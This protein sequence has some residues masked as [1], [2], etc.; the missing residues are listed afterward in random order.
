[1]GTTDINGEL[2]YTI[3]K[4]LKA[5]NY[6]ITAT[7]TGY[8]KATKSIDIEKYVDYR[9]GIEMPS[10]ANQY[11]TITIKVLY[12]G[13]AMSG[14]SVLFDNTSIGTTDSNG[15]VSYRLETS[16]THSITA[17][18][19]SYIAVSRDVDIRA[20]YSEFKALDINVTPNPVFAGEDFMIKSNIT[21]V[22]TKS[23][24]LPVDLIINGT[25]VDNRTITI[26]T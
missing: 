26:G 20:P 1:M 16:G 22:G 9:L 24:T 6:T 18:K 13:S 17:S 25:V 10:K 8:E 21:N 14:A 23:D 2:N 11:E 19:T 15:E 12:N 3:P 5:G 7:K 4:T